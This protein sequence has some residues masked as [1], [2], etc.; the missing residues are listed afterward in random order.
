VISHPHDPFARIDV[1]DSARHV[2][3]ELGGVVLAESSAPRA[4]FETGLPVRYYLPPDDVRLDLLTRSATT[5]TCAYK[6]EAGYYSADL[7]GGADVAWYYD[8]PLADAIPV[9]GLVAFW[10][11]RVE[12]YVDGERYA[13]GMPPEL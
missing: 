5:T 1:L 11:E 7:P 12:L 9:R 2:R 8:D 3:A 6:G 4:L 10:S 13:E